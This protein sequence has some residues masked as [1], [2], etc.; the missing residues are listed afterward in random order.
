M[1]TGNVSTTPQ[2]IIEQY[3]KTDMVI[4]VITVIVEVGLMVTAQATQM[5]MEMP[6]TTMV[7]R[8]N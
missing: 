4:A 2:P 8:T 7:G 1:A 5:V 6:V 3:Q